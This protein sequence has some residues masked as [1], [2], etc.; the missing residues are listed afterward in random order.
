MKLSSYLDTKFLFTNIVADTKEE[1]IKKMISKVSEVDR[2]FATSK[3][4]I[5][6]SV[7]QREEEISTAIG[8]GIAIPH[9]RVEG[10][11]DV[12]VAIATLK[13]PVKCTVATLNTEDDVDIFVLIVAESLKNKLMLKLMSGITKIALRKPEILKNIRSANTPHDVYQT[14]RTSDIE[15][16]DRITAEDI[17]NPEIEPV[18]VS[19]TLEEVA[20]RLAVEN[21]TGFPV[22]DDK[23]KFL[24]EIT[25]RELIEYG[26]PKYTS[27]LSDLSF[28]TVGEPFEE[29]FKNEKTVTVK[30]IYRKNPITV[31]RRASIM[32]IGFLMVTKGNTRIYVVEKGKYYGMILRS[33]LIKKVLHV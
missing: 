23:G 25:E 18:K 5:E 24:G 1:A 19:D 28:M 9:A 32:E 26:M 4:D 15:I 31:D 7:M 3:N 8:M 33:Y 29:Y 11:D 21:I 16:E 10:Y 30:E 20:K 6:K 12:V 13:K 22:V 27:L 17:M 2:K 14:I